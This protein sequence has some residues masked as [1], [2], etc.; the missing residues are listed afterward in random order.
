ML[1]Q[2][3]LTQTNKQGKDTFKSFAKIN[4]GDANLETISK[5]IAHYCKSFKELET[6]LNKLKLNVNSFKKSLPL[7]ITLQG[8]SEGDE[9]IKI[10]LTY[11]NFGKFIEQTT[12]ANLRKS[13]ELQIKFVN[14]FYNWGA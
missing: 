4:I 2:V 11:K 10:S 13:L 6:K 5:E 14:E 3:N 12:E 1:L 9:D 7:D 8:I